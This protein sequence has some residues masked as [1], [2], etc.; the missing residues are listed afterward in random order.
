MKTRTKSARYEKGLILVLLIIQIVS[1]KAQDFSKSKLEF[2]Q[3]SGNPFFIGAIEDSPTSIL[4]SADGLKMFVLGNSRDI[5]QYSMKNA[6]DV[7]TARFDDV[8]H[9][10]SSVVGDAK[11]MTFSSDGMK[12]FI[13]GTSDVVAQYTLSTAYDL[14]SISPIPT[15]TFSV[16][17]QTGDPEKIRFSNDGMRMFI[18]SPLKIVGGQITSADIFQ[19]DLTVAY[20][21]STASYDSNL[22]ISLETGRAKGMNFSDD[23]L[24]MYLITSAGGNGEVIISYT[25]TT[26]YDISTASPV[27]GTR[28]AFRS[29]TTYITD[30][31]FSADGSHMFVI[32]GD[33]KDVLHYSLGIAF[34]PG[35]ANLSKT[36]GNPF[37]VTRY[38]RPKGL[39][40]SPDGTKLYLISDKLNQY[41]MSTPYDITSATYDDKSLTV[42]DRELIPNG[43]AISNDGT[44]LFI[45]GVVSDAVNQYTLAT[46]F[47]IS[48]ATF[49]Q[50]FSVGAQLPTAHDITFSTDGM[51]M[52]IVGVSTLINFGTVVGAN[53]VYQYSLSSAF[54]ISTASF[55]N[56]ILSVASQEESPQGLALSS[57]GRKMFVVGPFGKKIYQYG[58]ATPYDISTGTYDNIEVPL[59]SNDPNDNPSGIFFSPDATKAFVTS[60]SG[61][62]T[63]YSIKP[64][65]EPIFHTE[66]QSVDFMENTN[67][68]VIDVDAKD[69]EG[70][71][72]D[73][74][75]TYSLEGPD[76]DLFNI[77]EIGVI[78]F[79]TI[80]DFEA[81]RDTDNNN[82]YQ[83]EVIA[84][85]TIDKTNRI[86]L[87][88]NVLDVDDIAPTFTSPSTVSFAENRNGVVYLAKTDEEVEEFILETSNDG[89]LFVLSNINEIRFVA[90]P[91]FE[92]PKD[93]DA[94]NQYV[95]DITAVDAARNATTFQVTITVTDVDDTYPIFT[96][97]NSASFEENGTGVVYSITTNESSTF[98]LGSSK[99][100]SLF[101]LNDNEISFVT[102][103]DFEN[104]K[105]VDTNNSY[106][107]DIIATNGAGNSSTLEVTINV[108]DVDDN[109]LSVVSSDFEKIVF[110]PNPITTGY[111]KIDL[112]DV[113][114]GKL[115]LLD[116]NG[117]VILTKRVSGRETQLDLSKE[118]PGTYIVEVISN[119]GK[120]AAVARIIKN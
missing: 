119:Q 34:R 10:V 79:K 30:F 63:Q 64:F 93:A 50:A 59:I 120:R 17:S 118:A 115:K 9:S 67:V 84:K 72:I 104:P 40:F 109:V 107:I 105:D 61:V 100:E 36:G 68:S 65:P 4:L 70:G 51:K 48:T 98:S 24:N 15:A 95:I 45:I 101:V 5:S 73:K 117:R 102:E 90:A 106:I 3:V 111:V 69:G 19:Y 22:D 47:D 18:T 81:P 28:Y 57:D 82:T 94:N 7:T 49:D 56:K 43:V 62:V 44:K 96:S 112:G 75:L 92:D 55:D 71:T 113:I 85:N 110:Y 89:E 42:S 78:V 20:D 80:P 33:D 29:E 54:D 27:S 39:T 86:E 99:D 1:L 103:P 116:S 53:E 23:G 74:N 91:D 87:T 38:D 26:A 46:P 108:T 35:T 52:F 13:V 41:S 114:K 97:P 88:I 31:I 25:L 21:I 77:N 37:G 76:A 16:T 32:T 58:L 14:S 12:I 11:G 2:K 60:I 8:V 83:I 66:S 6:F